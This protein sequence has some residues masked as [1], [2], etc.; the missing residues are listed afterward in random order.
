LGR[1]S[2]DRSALYL[3]SFCAPSL[4]LN[5]LWGEL[6]GQFSTSIAPFCVIYFLLLSKE[7]Y[8]YLLV[9]LFHCCAQANILSGRYSL[10]L[11][12]GEELAVSLLERMLAHEPADR[13]PTA[14]ILKHP[15]FWSKVS[16]L[17]R[18]LAH[19]P[20]DRPPTAAILKHQVFWSKVCR[21]SGLL[22]DRPPTAVILKPPVFWAR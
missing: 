21:L 22:V 15:V 6:H 7:M 12:E 18:M 9:K 10:S 2:T 19:E 4:L 20:A 5:A 11:V 8:Q 13:P 16:L 1:I 14:A 17:E 3:F